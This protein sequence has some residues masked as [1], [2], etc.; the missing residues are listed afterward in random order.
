MTPAL[1]IIL[2]TVLAAAA[3]GVRAGRRQPLSLESWTLGGRHF[4]V[5]LMWLLMAGEVY[6]TFTFLGAS[7]WAY[8]RGAPVFYI[9]IYGTLGYVLSFFLLPRLWRIGKSRGLHTQPDF[10]ASVY[11]SRTLGL[12]VAVVGIASLLPYLQLQL[13]GLGLIVE[14]ASGGAVPSAAA[15]VGAFVLTCVFVFT[16]GLRGAAWVAVLKDVLMIAAVGI[17]GIGVPLKYFGGFGGLFRALAERHPGH[18]VL[19]GATADMGVLWVMSTVIV[20]G[21]GFYMWPHM[22]GTTFSARSE[23]VLRRNAV[24]MPI[25]QLFIVLVFLAGFTALLVVPGLKNGDL[26]F[27]AIVQKTYPSWFL[28]FVG[29]AGAVTAMVPAAVLVLSA[30][31]LLAKNVYQAGFRPQADERTVMRLSRALVPVIMAVALLFALVFPSALVNLLLIGYDGVSQLFP[32]TVLG[33][34]WKRVRAE[35]VLAGLLAGI[36]AAAGLVFTGHDPLG[37]INAGFLAL[38][39]NAALAVGLSLALGPKREPAAHA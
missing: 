5:L 20:T 27:L 1:A 21:A 6:T 24:I 23:G 22:A 39:L 29:A 25:Y 14:L 18:L 4:G 8:T 36:A 28:G 15:I 26:A 16:S 13:R 30:A 35:A 2:F 12:V 11:G 19:P 34:F 32:G 7:G 9:P 17:V 38:A 31:T 33:L 10:F 37:G 3:L